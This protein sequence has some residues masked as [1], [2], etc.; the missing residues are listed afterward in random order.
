[1]Q[2][3]KAAE[4]QLLLNYAPFYGSIQPCCKVILPRQEMQYNIGERSRGPSKGS[5]HPFSLTEE[6]NNDKC[7]SYMF[8]REAM[9]Y[10]YKQNNC[11]NSKQRV[12]TRATLK[13]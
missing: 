6:V 11:Y 7:Y 2:T 1:M 10:I 3:N 8:K 12:P 9:G 4:A 13:Q 5:K